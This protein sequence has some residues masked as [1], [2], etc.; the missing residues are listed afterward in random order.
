MAQ[1]APFSRVTELWSRDS[2]GEFATHE[3]NLEF[4]VNYYDAD[5]KVLWVQD[6]QGA[7][8]LSTGARP[9]PFSSG[10]RV[11]V[12]GQ[13]A[14]GKKEI[15]WA[16][17]DVSVLEKTAW[18]A[19]RSITNSAAK[20]LPTEPLF[21]EI[22]GY[23]ALVRVI[24]TH[25]AEYL[26]IKAENRIRLFLQ[27]KDGEDPRKFGGAGVA[28]RGVLS[29]NADPSGKITD[30]T[31]WVPGGSNMTVKHRLEEDPRFEQPRVPVGEI[32]Q[33]SGTTVVVKGTVKR[34]SAGRSIVVWDKT[35]Q[36]TGRIW[37][38]GPFVPGETVEVAGIAS[39]NGTRLRL[40]NAVVRRSSSTA[41]NPAPMLL[42]LATHV[43]ELASEQ[44]A[45]SQPVMIKGVVTWSHTNVN[46][47]FVQ[48]SSG[49]VAV[50][51]NEEQMLHPPEVSREVVI[52]GVTTTGF[53]PKVRC[54]SL[55]TL[56]YMALPQPSLITLE[57]ALTG[58]E[59]SQWVELQ[60]YLREV[61]SEEPN[62]LRLNFTTMDGEFTAL[63]PTNT[64]WKEFAGSILRVR[65]VCGSVTRGGELA[66]I[67]L[68][69]PAAAIPEVEEPAAADPFSAPE[70][71]IGSLLKFS[72]IS[73]LNRRVSVSGVVTAHVPRR[74]LV[75]QDGTD[76]LMV[77]S[78]EAKQFQP[79]E[80]V[81]A[82]G[83]VGRE[84][85]RVVL[86][87]AM[88]R[89]VD[90]G[91][92]PAAKRLGAGDY[93][94]ERL[95]STIV[96]VEGRFLER[97][98]RNGELRF[99]VRADD[100]VYEALHIGDGAA[101]LHDI[102][103]DS[104]V[105]VTGVCQ[106]QLDEYRKPLSQR[107]LL[108]SARDVEVLK[109][110]PLLTV[111]R[112]AIALVAL[113][114]VILTG[115]A[116]VQL[117]LRKVQSQT[118]QI[119]AQL[120]HE[121][122][123]Q[124]QYRSLVENASDWIYTVD[125][126]G[127]IASSNCAGERV[128]G[129]TAEQLRGRSFSELVHE[130]DQQ[131]AAP[132][133]EQDPGRSVAV[134]QQFRIQRRSGDV[135]WIETHSTPLQQIDGKYQWLGVARDTTERKLIE[136]KLQEAKEAAEASTRAKSE[137][138][139][140]MSHEIR[141]PMNGV[142]GMSN[143]LLDTALT[144]EQR[145]FT[146]TIKNSAEALLTVINDILD[147][148]K[149]EAGKLAFETLAFDLRDT[150][151]STIDLL[152]SRAV[153]KNI[154]LNAFIPNSV[155]C[156]LEGDPGRLRQVLMNLIANGI[157]FT[158]SGEVAITVSLEEESETEV[159]ILFEIRDTGIGIAPEIQPLLFQPFTQADSSTTRRF[160]GTGLGLAI[161][162][163]IIEQM[164]GKYGVRSRPG[165][166]STF[167]FT[168]R[169]TRQVAA[170]APLDTSSLQGIRVLVVDDNG[171]NRKIVHHNIIA[172]GMRNGSVASGAEALNI[173]RK[174]A[175]EED[176]YRIAVLDYQMPGIDGL[177]LALRIKADPLI[178]KVRLILLT[179]L[180]TRL[181]PPVLKQHGIDLCLQKPFRQSELFNAI[182]MVAERSQVPTARPQLPAASGPKLP[183][184][185]VLVAEDNVVNQKV[186]LRQLE[187]LG[188]SAVAVS[189]G[190]E[191]IE[192]LDRGRYDAVLMD[193]QMPEMDG[194]E[195]TRAIRR[196]PAF[197]RAYI[198]AMT[199]NAMPG[200]KEKCI[201][202]GMN[203]YIP[204]PIRMADLEEALRKVTPAPHEPG[205]TER[206]SR[207]L[208]AAV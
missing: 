87:E 25:R 119:V 158:D 66:G 122:V 21:C 78:R 139:A 55:E 153:A 20:E 174:S 201:E 144:P 188:V 133:E 5:W 85:S 88:V 170:R 193:C 53:A 8:F 6:S 70:R 175:R 101:E 142:I 112:A 47:L 186:A 91:I 36:L 197:A 52:A 157:K 49:G 16:T 79:G 4:T 46:T 145:D 123:L 189:N 120:R 40:E 48:D 111:Q 152:A 117:L 121:A 184:M 26:L 164:G 74:F 50:I 108:R 172:W 154:E 136:E 191:A 107:I 105:R 28:V 169:L 38:S 22:E 102:R 195:A 12:K 205:S 126:T 103:P 32:P 110:P 86:R 94:D 54:T 39:A 194:Y 171:T 168:A 57:H 160:G 143:L 183:K 83:F 159:T 29:G 35:G 89:V 61:Q 135:V 132:T 82:V 10:D 64:P 42:T 141:T 208:T 62:L 163:G 97:Y 114:L 106:V 73:T 199:A 99:T 173:L 151:E 69:I 23:L 167:Y 206:Y 15:D 128:T 149:I 165:E 13:T 67:E 41:G 65:G 80:S 58:V 109:A 138:L 76:G 161:S 127:R 24:D 7:A 134:T 178:S 63:A 181:Q 34:F 9:L 130:Q 30:H 155:P 131:A 166:G 203:D 177:G 115:A 185:R 182:A 17:A 11:T 2:D 198:I 1:N 179:S 18:P 156:L 187:K 100:R 146:E 51:L 60:G 196:H 180:G 95:D 71:S 56:G 147:F 14:L 125:S 75:L 118:E 90:S 31:L 19:A 98:E 140:N 113:G 45:E 81:Q 202:S 137:F 92:V 96:Q 33:H 72:T 204:K 162:A 207:R 124:T 104:I 116:W 84:G 77:L 150:V 59:D 3:V 44:A 37:Q 93:L 200:D 192:A 68:W 129:Y 27:L 190:R 148:S 176:P 43:R